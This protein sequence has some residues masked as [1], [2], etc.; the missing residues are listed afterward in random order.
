MKRVVPSAAALVAL[1]AA[2]APAEAADLTP[3]APATPSSIWDGYYLGGHL[4]QGWANSNWSTPGASGSINMQQTLDSFSEAGSMF[5]GAQAGYDYKL[6]NSFLVG[7]VTDAS[8]PSFPNL[9]GF[10][11]G[12]GSYFNSPTAGGV[13]YTDNL[14]MFGTVR[15]RIGYTPG[16]WL[17]YATGGFAWSRDQLTLTQ[18]S[19][20]AVDVSQIWRVGWVVGAGVEAPIAPHWTAGLEYLFTD[21]GSSGTNFPMTIRI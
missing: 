16:N 8:F 5:V 21:Y 2:F 4:G 13:N 17:F 1:V 12:G 18:T 20:G 10:A 19:T 9:S 6:T 14:L 15:G 11:I 7:V 3:V